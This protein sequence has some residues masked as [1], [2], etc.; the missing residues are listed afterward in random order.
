MKLLTKAIK[1]KLIKNGQLPDDKKSQLKPVVKLFG[2]GSCTWLIA[3]YDPEDDLLFG[4]C[5]L[6]LGSPELGFV[7]LTELSNVRC[8]PFN[9]PVERDRHWSAD[10][11]LSEYADEANKAGRINS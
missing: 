9:L 6:G 5:D 3:E 4:L 10:K 1:T 2:G 11:T 8:K 7:C